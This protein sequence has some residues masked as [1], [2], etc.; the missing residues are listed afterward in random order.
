MMICINKNKAEFTTYTISTNNET[1]ITN[2]TL[3]A[4]I[5][6][7]EAKVLDYEYDMEERMLIV[8]IEN[9]I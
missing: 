4:K 8:L 3:G 7:P 2:L 9:T 6:I 5:T 1:T